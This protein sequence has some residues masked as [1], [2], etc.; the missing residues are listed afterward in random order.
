MLNDLGVVAFWIC[1][2]FE[3]VRPQIA[4]HHKIGRISNFVKLLPMISCLGVGVYGDLV[5]SLYCEW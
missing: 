2:Y 1:D 5:L 4:F 3:V